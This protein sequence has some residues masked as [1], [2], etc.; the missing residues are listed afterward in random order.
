MKTN[1]DVFSEDFLRRLDDYF[2]KV[3]LIK[4]ISIGKKIL[5]L[6][7]DDVKTEKARKI[8]K[9]IGIVGSVKQLETIWQRYFEKYLLYLIFWHQYNSF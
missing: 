2:I 5:D 7:S 1:I 4:I 6:K 3:K 8:I 9:E